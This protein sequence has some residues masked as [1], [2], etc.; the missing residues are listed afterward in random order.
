MTFIQRMTRQGVKQ[1]W[2]RRLYWLLII[3]CGSVL[4]LFIIASLLRLLMSSAGLKL[5]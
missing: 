4:A 1:P 2:W 3:W 5:H